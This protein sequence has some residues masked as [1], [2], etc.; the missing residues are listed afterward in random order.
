MAKEKSG[1]KKRDT[2]A[3]ASETPL[4]ALTGYQP[5]LDNAWTILP[6]SLQSVAFK[7]DRYPGNAADFEPEML[8]LDAA[9]DELIGLFTGV[10]IENVT[11]MRKPALQVSG[12]YVDHRKTGTKAS[13]RLKVTIRPKK[14]LDGKRI[15]EE[16]AI[17][18]KVTYG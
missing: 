12:T 15:V 9:K 8:A 17:W 18:T 13:G 1:S 5:P 4:R 3:R 16:E 14:K 6:E 2:A 11:L 10:T 7:Y